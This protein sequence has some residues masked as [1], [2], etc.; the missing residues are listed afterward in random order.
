V[1]L[2]AGAVSCL[3]IK[4]QTSAQADGARSQ[5]VSEPS[6]TAAG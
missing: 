2:V 6:A 1:F 5:E 4:R 3:L